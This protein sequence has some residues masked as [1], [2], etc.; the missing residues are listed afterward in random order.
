MGEDEGTGMPS[1]IP[2]FRFGGLNQSVSLAKDNT[3]I[4]VSGKTFTGD[5]EA[6]LELIPRADIIINTQLKRIPPH[7]A[8]PVAIGQTEIDSFVFGGR[9]IEG[10]SLGL[11]GDVTK[12]EFEL[13]W[14]PRSEP[15]FARGDNTTIIQ[16]LMFHVFN[17]K[18]IQGSRRIRK[19]TDSSGHI[20]ECVDL[21]ADGWTVELQSLE[22]SR[23]IFDQLRAEGGYGLTHVGSLKKTDGSSFSGKDAEEALHSLRFFISF[24]KGIW[25][26][27][28]CGVGFDNDGNRVWESWSSPKE[29][30]YRP[31]SWFDEHHPEQLVTLF[32]GFM[33]RWKNE[34]WREALHEVIYWYLNSN[35]SPRGIDAGI[36][37][38]QAAIERLSYAYA[39]KDRKLLEAKGF[40]DLRASDKFRMLFSSLDIPI[41][42][43][44]SLSE[45]R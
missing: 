37:L 41:D 3:E 17:F 10:F 24:A 43:Q 23:E 19:E 26:T 2:A 42:I 27:P 44:N 20:I 11:G 21:V 35:Y 15:I 30:W 9:K 32:P 45:M 18:N 38:T 25:C 6:W 13:R 1:L 39:V 28:I 7:V 33:A 31:I 14:C 8:M 36:I 34:E 22:T 5:G 4:Q 40:K 29:A 12:Q 16:D